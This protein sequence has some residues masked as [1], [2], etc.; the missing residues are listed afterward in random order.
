MQAIVTKYLGP[1]NSRGPRIKA[2]C[3][4]G[5]IEVPYDHAESEEAAHALAAMELV[6]KLGWT[7]KAG[8]MGHW[9]TGSL[10]QKDADFYT[11][12][13]VD[14]R[15]AYADTFGQVTA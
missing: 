14:G 3:D 4:A 12:V 13:Y 9:V 6:R 15:A 8:Y 7:Y 10:P 1:T 11:F 5:S 2:R